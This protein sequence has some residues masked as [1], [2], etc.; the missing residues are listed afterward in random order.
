MRSTARLTPSLKEFSLKSPAVQGWLAILALVAFTALG[1]LVHVGGLL[2]LAYPAGCFL[3]GAFLYLR[4]SILYL[5]F[6]WWIW[7]LS[8]W[9]RRLIDLHSGWVDPSP[10]LLAPFLTTLVTSL[11]LLRY[12][13]RA[14][15]QG[16]LPFILP[17]SAVLYGFLV[18]LVN[19]LVPTGLIGENNPSVVAVIVALLNWLTP[20]LFGFHLFINWRHYPSYRQNLQRTF[21]AGVLVM[22]FYGVLQYLIAPEWDNFWL[23][24]QETEV[25]GYP[26]PFE[27]RVFSTMNSPQ[28]FAYVIASGLVLI[29]SARGVPRFFAAGAGYLSLLLSLVRSAWMGWFVSVLL[30]I[31]AFKPRLQMRLILTLLVMALLVI[32]LATTEPFSQVI[33]GRMESLIDVQQDES[34]SARS[35]GYNQLLG[36]A[37]TE[38]IGKGM[39]GAFSS[40]PLGGNDSGILTLLFLLGWVGTLPYVAGLVLMLFKMAQPV[41]GG[42]DSFVGTSRAIVL[43]AF[44][45]IGLNNVMLGV[46]GMVLWSFLGIVLAAQ[47]YYGY[48]RFLQR[49]AI[50]ETDISLCRS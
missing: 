1:V 7:F 10:V 33:S 2:R 50:N 43:G 25:F 28:P 4:H 3:V 35:D 8:P 5:G 42:I 45:Q 38:F 12:L 22:G 31:P 49:K 6:T 32:P 21:I 17:L 41:E 48:Q 47:R 14:Y 36:L 18:G 34:Y 24:N 9:V 19:A 37:V 15:Q 40:D 30:L 11:T 13:P 27:I 39:G 44:V 29:F 23:E 16:G 46:F 20:I 26:E